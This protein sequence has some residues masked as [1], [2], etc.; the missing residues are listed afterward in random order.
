MSFGIFH[1]LERVV[2]W[3]CVFSLVID[4]AWT[5]C[6]PNVVTATLSRGFSYFMH[7]YVRAANFETIPLSIATWSMLKKKKQTVKAEEDIVTIVHL[8]MQCSNIVLPFSTN[9]NP[10]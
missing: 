9:D 6:F 7:I 5:V 10:R 3:E 8:I 1:Q 4:I 2:A